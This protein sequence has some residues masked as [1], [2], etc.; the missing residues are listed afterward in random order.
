MHR[1]SVITFCVFFLAFNALAGKQKRKLSTLIGYRRITRA[2][3]PL[4]EV[5]E[6]NSTVTVRQCK[7]SDVD[8][9]S[10]A[11]ANIESHCRTNPKCEN[12]LALIG[13][14]RRIRNCMET[15]HAEASRFELCV[16]SRAGKFECSEE[17]E[18][19]NI[20]LSRDGFD[21]SILR[22]DEKAAKNKR[23]TMKPTSQNNFPQE[24]AEYFICVG[25]CT[26]TEAS[27]SSEII[28]CSHKLKCAL[29]PPSRSSQMV[30]E[31]CSRL[32]G[33]DPLQR[34]IKSCHCL[35]DAGANVSCL[36]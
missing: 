9:C 29:A 30:M 1:F 32:L 36:Y 21:P 7:C 17:V 5:P 22:D 12:I 4:S 20:T 35:K 23:S 3:I 2:P 8:Q 31:T 28:E 10:E 33:L 14:V 26:S 27:L 15:D 16:R 18:P 25:Q 19:K 11:L 34:F 24:L 13:N 6:T